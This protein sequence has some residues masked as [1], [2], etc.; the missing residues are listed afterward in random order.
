MSTDREQPWHGEDTPGDAHDPG[1][2]G[3]DPGTP[4]GGRPGGG[5]AFLLA[6]LG[7]YAAERFAQRIAELDLTPAQAGLLRLLVQQPGRSQRELAD[8]LGMPP[9]RFV[10]FADGLEQRGLIERRRN[11]EDR[12]LYALHLTDRGL[13]LLGRLR[14]TALTH[15]RDL[16]QALTPE[17]HAR[18]T[19]LLT[20]V[21]AQQG[22]TPGI[23]PGYRRA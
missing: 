15:E 16:T 22:L 7:A 1:T 20:R 3:G 14:D 6:Q 19:A 2:P 10:P 5:A 21:A 11:T 18:L 17:E 4:G 12:R 23:H 13:A 8:A 9:S